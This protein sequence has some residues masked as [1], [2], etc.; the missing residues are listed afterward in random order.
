MQKGLA[1]NN[2]DGISNKIGFSK[3]SFAEWGT[4]VATTFKE[5]E[6][7]VNRFK[8]TLKTMFTVQ[9]ENSDNYFK[10]AF[11]EIVTKDN[12]DSYIPKITESR[13]NEIL[14]EINAV[15]Q[16]NGSWNDYYKTLKSGE[17]YVVD[18][19]KN[20]DD[21]S[22]L[23]GDDLVQANQN[24]REA[25]LAH[26]NGLKQMTLGA[27]AA[28]VAMKALS[29]AGNM[30]VYALIAKGIELAVTAIDNYIHRVE[31]AN[32][33]IQESRDSY[34]QTT[35][36]LESVNS[37]LET[38]AQRIDEINS[39]GKL[40]LTD[41]EDLEKLQAQTRELQLQQSILE[42]QKQSEATELVSR[43]VLIN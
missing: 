32:E 36:D 19:I 31:K 1:K 17:D 4:Q 14:E 9:S 21:L 5:S 20:T 43:E 29:I 25:V 3:R 38:T 8:N 7:F 10:N 26:N 27:K 35:S 16:A 34:N 11:G 42:K 22:K 12:I 39:K 6:G 41:K 28:N 40:E 33:K 18:L 37:E 13:T 15:R 23:T 24:A 2:L 30:I